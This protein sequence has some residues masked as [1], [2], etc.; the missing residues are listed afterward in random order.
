MSIIKLNN[1]GVKDITTFGSVSSLGT[2]SLIQKQTASSSS[3]INFTSGIDNSFKEYIFFFNNIHASANAYIRV[4]FR[5]GSSA[6]D[7]TKTTTMFYSG[8]KEDASEYQT[9]LGGGGNSLGNSTAVQRIISGEFDTSN[10][11]TLCGYLHLYD[12]SNTTHIKHFIANTQYMTNSPASET[13]YIA[14][15]CNT[16]NAIDGAQFDM[17]SG[18]IEYGDILLF[19]VN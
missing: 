3:T 17:S 6:Y 19:G 9:P 15:Y 11:C 16:T 13:S 8:Q 7:S 18:T 12:P 14:G 1:R 2:L 5:D 10:D 4:N